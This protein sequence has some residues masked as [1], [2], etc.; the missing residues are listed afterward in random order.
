[1]F[2]DFAAE[3]FRNANENSEQFFSIEGKDQLTKELQSLS[4]KI[5]EIV[6]KKKDDACQEKENQ[7]KASNYLI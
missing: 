7:K 4:N 5:W 6:E 3:Y 2:E 1:M